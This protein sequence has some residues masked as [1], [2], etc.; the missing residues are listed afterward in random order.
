MFPEGARLTDSS[1][2]T[3]VAEVAR[4]RKQSKTMLLRD[5]MKRTPEFH[6]LLLKAVGIHRWV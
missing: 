3:T 6:C 2:K 1:K 4:M 5:K